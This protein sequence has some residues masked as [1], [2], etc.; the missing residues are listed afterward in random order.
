MLR[1]DIC[2]VNYTGSMSRCP[3]CQAPLHGTPEPSPLPD[4]RTLLLPRL[5]AARIITFAIIVLF[6][7]TLFFTLVFHWPPRIMTASA[8]SLLV[9][10]VFANMTIRAGIHP[11]HI[12]FRFGY[13]VLVCALVWLA[14]TH[15]LT[16]TC[17]VIPITLL[18][19]LAFSAVT[20]IVLRTRAIARYAKYYVAN[21]V[22]GLLPL[23]FFPLH[24]APW[25]LLVGVCVLVSLILAVAMV[26]FT[27]SPL[28]REVRKQLAL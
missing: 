11:L 26:V 4:Q 10:G 27:W 14:C 24:W 3:L 16:I 8:I 6:L 19:M 2:H 23:V 15:N 9:T 20:L 1:C 17:M 28:S 7:L 5:L 22:C 12:L 13:I 18:S 25:P 21:V